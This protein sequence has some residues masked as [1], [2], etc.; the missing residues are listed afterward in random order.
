M[1][2][3][4]PARHPRQGL[5]LP[6]PQSLG[7]VRDGRVGMKALVDQ[8]QQPHAPGI[9]VPVVFEAQEVAVGGIG[10]DPDE[11]RVSG[12]E[13]LVVSADTDAGKIL[14]GVDG[15]S[16]IDGLPHD[17][18]NGTQRQGVIEDI[19]QQLTDTA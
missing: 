15:V 5:F 16:G 13:D 3:V 11:D 8:F 14:A 17:I 18:V 4:A 2:H 19:G 10:I 12:L 7:R 9:S 6:S 1:E